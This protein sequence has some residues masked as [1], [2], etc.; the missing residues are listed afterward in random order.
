MRHAGCPTPTIRPRWLLRLLGP[1]L[2]AGCAV[3]THPAQ[4]SAA[5]ADDATACHQAAADAA[6]ASGRF[7]LDAQNAYTVCMQRQGWELQER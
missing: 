2:F 4:P 6:L 5:F 3:W 1:C 7:D